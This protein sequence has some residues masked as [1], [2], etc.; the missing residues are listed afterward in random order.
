MATSPHPSISESWARIETW[1]AAHA[2]ATFAALGPPASASAIDEA[3]S[4]LGLPFPA[5]LR[6]SLLRHDGC[7][8]H[9]LFAPFWQP[10]SVAG[11]VSSWRLRV[12]IH[13]D[14]MELADE[15][16]DFGTDEA[17]GPWWHSRWIP[18]AADGGGDYLVI[19]QRPG[20]LRGR[21]GDACHEDVCR[22]GAHSMW[23]S[24]PALFTATATLLESGDK[25][26]PRRYEPST[27]EDGR[28]EW[29]IL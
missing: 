9:E 21:L 27:D 10:L 5:A 4:I 1:L 28:L 29:E 22:F 17:Y 3:E 6:E 7:G 12:E 25:D 23:Q 18:V 19:D 14:D 15:D 2:P 16:E 11:I 8:Y 24:L 26:V 13:G 20:R